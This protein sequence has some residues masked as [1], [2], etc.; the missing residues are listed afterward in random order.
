MSLCPEER[1]DKSYPASIEPAMLLW[2]RPHVE[3]EERNCMEPRIY[4]YA[5]YRPLKRVQK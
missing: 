4:K 2:G 1:K 5:M 3:C